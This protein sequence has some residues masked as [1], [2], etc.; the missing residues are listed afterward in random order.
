MEQESSTSAQPAAPQEDEHPSLP[1][2]SADAGAPQAVPDG[3]SRPQAARGAAPAQHTNPASLDRVL[4]IP[5]TVQVELGRTRRT[6]REV[7]DLEPGSVVELD[8]D[9]G[10]P[11]SVY[12]NHTLVA[13]GEAVVVGGRY[14]VRITEIVSPAQ[15]VQQ[16]GM[17]G[18]AS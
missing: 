3:G 4:G 13:Q 14:G 1:A 11:L 10:K 2:S 16:L 8:S 6:V 7:L 15:R 18:G 12:V 9:P 17:A 5:V